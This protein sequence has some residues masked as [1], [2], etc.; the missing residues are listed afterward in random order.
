M[1]YGSNIRL[2]RKAILIFL[3]CNTLFLLSYSE[4]LYGTNSYFLPFEKYNNI[5]LDFLNILENPRLAAYWKY[6]V[7]GQIISIVAC[8]FLPYKRLF[9]FFVYFFTMNLYHKTI[10]IQ[11]AGFNLLVMTLFLLIFMDENANNNKFSFWKTLNITVTNFA[12]WASRFQVIILYVVATYFK[13]LGTTWL[14]GTAFYYIL[15]NDTYSHPWFKQLLI[16]HG[17]LTHAITWFALLFQLLFPILIWFK[18][19]KLSMIILGV[20]FHLMIIIIMGITDFGI[21]ML[22]MYLLFYTPEKL[23]EKFSF[24]K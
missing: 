10:P 18:K 15:Y 12:V 22:I 21:I 8:L 23:K 19:T 5:V 6:F 7:A 2:F 4:T 1:P 17:F 20:L 14:D 16:S 9:T 11:N 13:L 3:L 24:S